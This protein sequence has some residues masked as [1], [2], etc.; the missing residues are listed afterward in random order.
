[1][2][3]T[4]KNFEPEINA[5]LAWWRKALYAPKQDNGALDGIEYYIKK[6]DAETVRTLLTMEA[7]NK[8]SS[9]K[10]SRFNTPEKLDLFEVSARLHLQ[11]NLEAR[12]DGQDVR[13][14]VDYHSRRSAVPDL[15]RCGPHRQAGLALQDR[16]GHSR[17]PGHCAVWLLLEA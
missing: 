6:G 9:E 7:M 5:A 4:A 12:I 17:G 3:D 1:V 16:H 11:T 8:M 13:L 10:P 14:S 15:P 2:T